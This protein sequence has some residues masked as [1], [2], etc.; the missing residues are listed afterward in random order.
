MH[1]QGFDRTLASLETRTQLTEDEPY[2][3]LYFNHMNLALKDS[4]RTGAKGAQLPLNPQIQALLLEMHEA[5]SADSG[6]SCAPARLG[7]AHLPPAHVVSPRKGS[8][9]STSGDATDA[10][11]Q[12]EIQDGKGRG[13][14]EAGEKAD[15]AQMVPVEVAVKTSNDGWVVGRRSNGRELYVLG[16]NQCRGLSICIYMCSVRRKVAV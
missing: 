2:R 4:L 8:H 6:D 13:G 7:P 11:V 12:G 5:F 15:A 16:A 10:D 3:Y 1:V 9:D 14:Q